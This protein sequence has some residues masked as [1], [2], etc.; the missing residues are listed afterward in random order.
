MNT[1]E[2]Y[3]GIDRGVAWTCTPG[4]GGRLGRW[5]TTRRA[6]R[7]SQPDCRPCRWRWWCWRLRGRCRRWRWRP[8]PLRGC[9]WRWSI[10]GR[11]CPRHRPLG[12]DRPVGRKSSP[13][14]PRP[15]SPRWRKSPMRTAKGFRSVWPVGGSWWR[16]HRPLRSTQDPALCKGV[17]AHIRWLQGRTVEAGKRTQ[18]HDTPKPALA[19]EGRCVLP[20][21][22]PVVR[23][24][25]PAGVGSAGPAGV[26]RAG[27]CG[28][29]WDSGARRGE[30]HIRGGRAPVR[31][32]LYMA[33]WWGCEKTGGARSLPTPPCRKPPKQRAGTGGPARYRAHHFSIPKSSAMT[34]TV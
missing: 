33:A 14:L 6:F 15:S 8:W 19:G 24:R 4:P 17:Q 22:G 13:A 26:G 32:A 30:R 20:G 23:A 11:C 1:Q 27:G 3:V 9:R 28:A 25:W 10:P 16:C 2:V 5:T 21:I 7:R 34:F 18:C 31:R 29:D 12:E